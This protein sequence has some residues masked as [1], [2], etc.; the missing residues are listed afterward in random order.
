MNRDEQ[1]SQ[2]ISDR[3]WKNNA[4]TGL[5]SIYSIHCD[6]WSWNCVLTAAFIVVVAVVAAVVVAVAVPVDVETAPFTIDAYND[7]N[8]MNEGSFLGIF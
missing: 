8:H 1:F 2:W 3:I 5:L 6:G 7:G 4:E